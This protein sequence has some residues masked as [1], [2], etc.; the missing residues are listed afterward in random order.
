MKLK[1]YAIKCSYKVNDIEGK[2]EK[3]LMIKGE[4]LDGQIQIQPS[5]VDLGIIMV[6]FIKTLAFSIKNLSNTNFNIKV[7][8]EI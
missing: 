8:L 7:I 1:S 2:K 5:S 3:Y 6:N 4:G